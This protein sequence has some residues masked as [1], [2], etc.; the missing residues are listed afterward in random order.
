MRGFPKHLNIK[1]D[2]VNAMSDF[3]KSEWQPAL[4]ELLDTRVQWIMT[5]KLDGE[6]ITDD[7]HEVRETSD[8]NGVVTERYQY[9]YK[10]DPNCKL[11]RLG[12]T[13]EEVEGYING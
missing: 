7:T 10:E 2:Y 13:L 5:S 9:E 12:F 8:E 1:Q 3:P 4:Q 6:G 11:L